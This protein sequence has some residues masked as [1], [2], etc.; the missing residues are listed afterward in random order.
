[1]QGG[2]PAT[3]H[4][5][6]QQPAGGD[7][8]HGGRAL[9]GAQRQRD[10]EREQDE[11]QVRGGEALRQRRA[12]AAGGE[13]LG[14]HA[15]CTLDRNGLRPA[16]WTLTTDGLFIIASEA[17]VLDIAAERVQ[18]KG[19]LGPGEMIAVDLQAGCL[20]DNDAIDAINRARAPYK[21]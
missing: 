1:M 15:A 4:R 6:G 10:D 20:L 14:K 16:R 13:H 7:D 12:N 9:C 5:I 8:G 17:G 18:A 21:A 11:W 3:R 2:I 19:K